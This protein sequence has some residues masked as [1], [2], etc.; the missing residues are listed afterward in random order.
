MSAAGGGPGAA[1]NVAV[2]NSDS[3]EECGSWTLGLPADF[4]TCAHPCVRV[5]THMCVR[6]HAHHQEPPG[7]LVCALEQLCGGALE[8]N[9]LACFNNIPNGQD[10]IST[11]YRSS[12][13]AAYSE[14]ESMH[15]SKNG[16]IYTCTPAAPSHLLGARA[17]NST[18]QFS[19]LCPSL[20]LNQYH[21]QLCNR[22]SL[23]LQTPSP[24]TESPTHPH[25]ASPL[26][27]PAAGAGALR[28][29]CARGP[30]SSRGLARP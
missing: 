9:I 10:C 19:T 20:Q 1:A 13:P 30:G 12:T 4:A 29:G 3:R 26:S 15:P 27:Q 14:P 6:A 17:P 24:H 28:S 11:C 5:R 18:N 7:R 16:G 25:P 22:C 23:W 2:I 21:S 8:G